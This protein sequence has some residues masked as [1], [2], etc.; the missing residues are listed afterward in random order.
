[1]EESVDSKSSPKVKVLFWRV[2]QRC[3]PTKCNLIEKG[4]MLEPDCAV[5]GHP[6]ETIKHIFLE[7]VVSTEVWRKICP[8]LLDFLED[9]RDD[10]NS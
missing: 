3:I 1:M 2:I 8:Q 4:I 7:C 10:I 5:C 6:M 9:H